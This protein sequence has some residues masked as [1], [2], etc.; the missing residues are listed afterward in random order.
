VL[1][2]EQE[3]RQARLG[4]LAKIQN[5]FLQLSDISQLQGTL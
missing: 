1:C 5:L 2:P 4:L 3:V